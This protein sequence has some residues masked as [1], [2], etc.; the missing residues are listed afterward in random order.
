MEFI[1]ALLQPQA[2]MATSVDLKRLALANSRLIN[3]AAC[4]PGGL[5]PCR[6]RDAGLGK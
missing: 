6:V 3:A 2:A 1:N 4:C 5:L